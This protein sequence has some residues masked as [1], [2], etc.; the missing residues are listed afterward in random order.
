[1]PD[2]DSEALALLARAASDLTALAATIEVLRRNHPGDRAATRAR[3]LV[4]RL[5]LTIA[6]LLEHLRG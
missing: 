5:E 6:D 3:I 4:D 1:M 2:W